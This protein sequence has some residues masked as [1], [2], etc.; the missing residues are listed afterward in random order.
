VGTVLRPVLVLE[1]TG[2]QRLEVLE[3]GV[4]SLEALAVPV[5]EERD[6]VLPVPLLL[7]RRNLPRHEVDAE[8]GQPLADG[9]GVRAPLGLVERQHAAMLDEMRA[10]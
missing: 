10:G 9:S 3:D 6:L 1:L 7:F 4:G 5:R 8:L 2:R